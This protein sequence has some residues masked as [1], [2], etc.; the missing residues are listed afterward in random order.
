MLAQTVKDRAGG[1]AEVLKTLIGSASRFR[2][3]ARPVVAGNAEA[4]LLVS[5]MRS[6]DPRVQMPPIGTRLPDEKALALIAR[7][8]NEDLDKESSR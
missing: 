3:D 5:R 4:S 1:A 6:R 7:W 8:I 2:S